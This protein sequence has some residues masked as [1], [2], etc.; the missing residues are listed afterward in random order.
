MAQSGSHREAPVSRAHFLGQCTAMLAGLAFGRPL[1]HLEHG[2]NPRHPLPHPEPRAGITSERVLTVETLG[3]R[4]D[5]VLAAYEAARR[6]PELFDGLACGCGCYGLKTPHRS[7]LVCYET[8]QP[9]GCQT[10]ASEA[11]FVNKLAE[12]NA[13]LADIRTAV[14]KEFG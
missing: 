5:K 1:P 11:T 9:T 6:H 12:Q 14:D 3:S 7:L 13:S 10:C 8:M 2:H 4:S